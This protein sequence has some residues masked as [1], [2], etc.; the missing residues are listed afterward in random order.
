MNIRLAP[1]DSLRV[2]FAVLTAIVVFAIAAAAHDIARQVSW[3]KHSALE[4]PGLMRA[5][6][7]SADIERLETSVAGVET[8]LRG[9]CPLPVS[10]RLMTL[11]IGLSRL[12]R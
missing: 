4:I 6:I 3:A 11:G 8:A 9:G 7:T 1:S 10:Q 12:E 2:S 5:G